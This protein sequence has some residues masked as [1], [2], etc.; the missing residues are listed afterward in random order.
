[1]LSLS[2]GL[3][4]QF[5]KPDQNLLIRHARLVEFQYGDVL[6]SV[7]PS[8][9]WV[10]F[11]NSGSVALFVSQ[12]SGDVQAGLAVGLVCANGALNLQ[13]AWGMGQGNI[14]LIV[15]SAGTAFRIDAHTLQNLVKRHLPWL[16]VFARHQWLIYQEISSL[17]A[18]S[19]VFATKQRLADWL[20][21]S[22]KCCNS[23][24]IFMTHSH[25]AKMLGVRRSSITLA[26]R[27]MKLKGLINYS[28]GQITLLNTAAL[29]VLVSPPQLRA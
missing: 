19:H 6:A 28:R 25:I 13:A 9:P 26:A 10:Y 18:L 11:L 8:L 20:L 3:I 16:N 24:S 12:Q 21:K 1:V 23:E 2:N 17:A 4:A 14:S 29:E 15:Q 7:D 22:A 27:E 5:S